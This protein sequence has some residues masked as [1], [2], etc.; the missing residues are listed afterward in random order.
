MRVAECRR[1]SSISGRAL[2]QDPVHPYF[3]RHVVDTHLAVPPGDL[4]MEGI[5]GLKLEVQESPGVVPVRT[6][7]GVAARGRLEVSTAEQRW[8]V[9]K[10]GAEQSVGGV[11]VPSAVIVIQLSNQPHQ[12]ARIQAEFLRSGCHAG[13]DPGIDVGSQPVCH[14]APAAWLRMAAGPS[15]LRAPAGLPR[16]LTTAA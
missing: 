12:L 5:V 11:R 9:I 13:A 2:L 16:G 6:A 7:P 15:G 1:P 14:G 4:P 8:Y 10:D 3:R